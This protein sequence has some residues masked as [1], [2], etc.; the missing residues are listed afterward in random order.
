MKSL[1]SLLKEDTLDI[2]YPLF[3]FVNLATKKEFHGIIGQYLLNNKEEFINTE[4]FFHNYQNNFAFL[5]N[6]VRIHIPFFLDMLIFF[7]YDIQTSYILKK[8]SFS[9]V[10]GLLS[11]F[12]RYNSFMLKE[13]A[14]M[15]KILFYLRIEKD[16]YLKKSFAKLVKSFLKDNFTLKI[17]KSF[18]SAFINYSLYSLF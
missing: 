12:S 17:L 14:F 15:E 3:F 2:C 8:F 4:V 6:Y 5:L 18:L 10:V 1:H 7:V 9:I 16:D 11:E 13:D